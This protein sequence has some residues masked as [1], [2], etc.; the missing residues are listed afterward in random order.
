MIK[1]KSFFVYLFLS[2]TFFVAI[3]PY[4]AAISLIIDKRL[5]ALSEN[6]IYINFEKIEFQFPI[7]V[8]F[9]NLKFKINKKL[10]NQ[11]EDLTFQIDQL[12]L[13][14]SPLDLLRG[15]INSNALINGFGGAAKIQVKQS[16]DR[17]IINFAPNGMNLSE[18]NLISKF[19]SKNLVITGESEFSLSKINNLFIIDKS[20]GSAKINS[21]R[22]L[23]G[24][25]LPFKL[26]DTGK[27]DIDLTFKQSTKN[28]LFEEFS[29]NSDLLTGIG[30]I[31]LELRDNGKFSSVSTRLKVSLTDVGS[32]QLSGYIPIFCIGYQQGQ[33]SFIINFEFKNSSPKCKVA[34]N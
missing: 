4:N 12:K 32:S 34:Y 5:E 22:L 19:V 20:S 9:N 29:I 24:D 33:N 26:P 30:D 28:I 8:S 16:Q 1:K 25:N 17:Y 23:L 11:S 10:I 31:D 13:N 27:V 15:S 7:N 14:F 21:T 6:G 2:I 18:I 3:F